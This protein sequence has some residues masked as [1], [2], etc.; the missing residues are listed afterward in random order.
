M[1]RYLS[2]GTAFVMAYGFIDINYDQESS[3]MK[4]E[5]GSYY[6]FI[7]QVNLHFLACLLNTEMLVMQE[8]HY[9]TWTVF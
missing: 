2:N 5:A 4:H 7:P 3:Y 8:N 1:C 6:F 9:L